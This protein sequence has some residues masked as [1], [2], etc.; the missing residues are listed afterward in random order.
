MSIWKI[1]RDSKHHPLG[2]VK[3]SEFERLPWF[4]GKTMADVWPNPEVY[5]F[6]GFE[7]DD[8]SPNPGDFPYFRSSGVLACS[9]RALKVIKPLV[10]NFVEILPLDYKD[11]HFYTLNVLNVVDCVDYTRSI[12]EYSQSGRPSIR[13]LRFDLDCVGDKPIFKIPQ[14]VLTTIF[15]SDVFKSLVENHGLVGLEFTEVPEE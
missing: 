10:A 13:R 7:D 8:D 9:E 6:Y 2:V 15:V 14:Y 11:Q 5:I 4:T 12:V 3:E 1:T